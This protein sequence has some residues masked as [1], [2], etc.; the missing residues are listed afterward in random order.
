M[1]WRGVS[2]PGCKPLPTH[3]TGGALPCRPPTQIAT[4][5]ISEGVRAGLEA[6]AAGADFLDLSE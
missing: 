3:N 6:A 4:N 5:Q 2:L 1:T